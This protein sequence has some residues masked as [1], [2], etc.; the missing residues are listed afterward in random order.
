MKT[1]IHKNHHKQWVAESKVMISGNLVLT[2]RTSKL[3]NGQLVSSASVGKIEG[4]FVSHKLFQDFHHN[5]IV[6]H[7]SRVTEK[8]VMAQHSGIDFEWVIGQACKF[9]QV[10][11]NELEMI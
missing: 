5:I 8:V 9:Y 11:S 3:S 4:G 1:T 2:I 10:E 7:P 6:S